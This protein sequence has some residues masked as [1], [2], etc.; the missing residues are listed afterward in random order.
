MSHALKEL[1][2]YRLAA[3]DGLVGHVEDFYFDDRDWVIRYLVAGTGEHWYDGRQVLLSPIS[4]GPA[5]RRER[6]LALSITREQIRHGPDIDTARPVSRQHEAELF[7]HYN[8]IP[9]WDGPYLWGDGP[10]PD[11]LYPNI[12]PVAPRLADAR[13]DDPNLRSAVEVRGY[14]VRASDGE[15]GKVVDLSV[16][17]SS[18]AVRGLIVETGHWWHGNEVSVPPD[19]ITGVD[20]ARRTVSLSLTRE[21]LRHLPPR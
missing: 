16:D 2:G 4:L 5:D 8:Y 10:F 15:L 11:P 6:T 17:E 21:R 3:V 20:W 7:A 13:D 1:E 9:Y 19:A 18:W 14:H 12:D